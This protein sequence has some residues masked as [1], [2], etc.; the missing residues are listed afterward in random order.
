MLEIDICIVSIHCNAHG[1]QS[2]TRKEKNL[3]FVLNH[4]R[5]HRPHHP[6]ITVQYS[7]QGSEYSCCGKRPGEPKAQA[8]Y[9]RPQQADYKHLLP[10]DTVRIRQ[11]TP[12]DRR[13][14]LCSRETGL[15]HTRLGRNRGIGKR[16]IEGFELVEHV[17]LQGCLRERFGQTCK[18]QDGELTFL[19]QRSPGC[20]FFARGVFI[21]VGSFGTVISIGVI[22]R[23]LGDRR[24]KLNA[25]RFIAMT[26]VVGH[27]AVFS[28][29]A[30]KQRPRGGICMVDMAIARK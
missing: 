18:G 14:E 3:L 6:N 28:R 5:N 22:A 17:R 15:Q 1:F 7:T 4:L 16:F 2:P 12:K 11:P 23:R 30:V 9:A 20:W 24:E 10:P 26:V 21:I 19:W 25:R 13:E 8:R 27:R 29:L